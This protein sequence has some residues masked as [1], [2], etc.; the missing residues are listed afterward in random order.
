MAERLCDSR[1]SG[2]WQAASVASTALIQPN[3]TTG[4]GSNGRKTTLMTPHAITPNK[5]AK[6]KPQLATSLAIWAAARSPL[7]ATGGEYELNS[8]PH[9]GHSIGRVSFEECSESMSYS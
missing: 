2:P 4:N 5:M 6:G 1:I 3:A 9:A 8:C 7:E